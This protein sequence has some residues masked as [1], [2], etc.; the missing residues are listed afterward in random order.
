MPVSEKIGRRNCIPVIYCRG[1]HYEVGFDV[2]RTFSSLIQSFVATSGPLNKV[3]LPLYDSPEGRKAYDATLATC[4]ENFPQ[5][6]REIEGTADGAQVPFHKLF[7]LHMDDILPN[8][9]Q[10]KS[11]EST[12]GCS[13]LCCN[14]PN[15]EI[16]G[17]N[18]DALAETLNHIYFVSAH[19][20]ED[21]PQGKWKVREEKFT[22]LCYAGHLPGFTMSYNHHGFVFSVNIVSAKTL[23]AGKTPRYFLTRALLAAENL[24][25][26]QQILRDA[27][28]GAAEGVSINMTFLSQEGDRVFHNAEV[29]PALNAK[30]SPLSILTVSPGELFFHTNKY[31]RLQ[32]PEV[33]GMIVSS[34]DS[35]HATQEG[36]PTP[37]TADD[38][39]NVLGDQSGKEFT[40]FREAG[41]D[42][43]VK[44]VAVGIFDCVNKTWSIYADNPKT[45]K[46]IVVLPI[47]IKS[48]K[49]STT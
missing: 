45:S 20:L 33:G 38:V 12:N 28:V 42:D 29:G 5:Y 19:I 26:A 39:I 36:M 24:L 22:S 31:L 43:F 16:L 21:S 44:T 10:K 15:Q 37:K 25:Q 35:R 47:E 18:E 13:T 30:E 40:I 6:V 4:K 8:S 32:I 9:V 46:P 1:T 14:Q 2:G 48:S 3:Y 49:N 23:I 11:S 41:D 27:G 34:S 17:H 7:L